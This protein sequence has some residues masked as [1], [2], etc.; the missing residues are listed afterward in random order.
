MLVIRQYARDMLV[1]VIAGRRTMILIY[2]RRYCQV[3]MSIH[4]VYINKW[5][6][7]LRRKSQHNHLYVCV[8]SLNFIAR[9]WR[10]YPHLCS[11]VTLWA[12][13]TTPPA[14]L[15]AYVTWFISLPSWTLSKLLINVYTFGYIRYIYS[16]SM[17]I[18]ILLQQYCEIKGHHFRWSAAACSACVWRSTTISN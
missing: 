7:S 12:C 17:Y 6:M 8:Y 16:I 4:A 5:V 1:N 10:L 14:N 18:S 2:R 13:L 11:A 3:Q 9:S 15:S